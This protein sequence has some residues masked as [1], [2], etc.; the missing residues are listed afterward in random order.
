MLPLRDSK[1]KG[2]DLSTGCESNGH[3]KTLAKLPV[4]HIQ[5]ILSFFFLTEIVVEQW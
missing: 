1:S 2:E 3:K 5:D 4:I